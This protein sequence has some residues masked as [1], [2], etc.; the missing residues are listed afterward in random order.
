M[1]LQDETAKWYEQYYGRFGSDRNNILKDKGVLWQHLASE[2]SLI[3]S[4]ASTN[5]DYA[6]AK[7][8]DI[9]CGSGSLLSKLTHIGFNPQNLTGIDISPERIADGNMKYPNISLQCGDAQKLPFSTCSYDLTCESTMFVQITDERMS[10]EIAKEMIRVTKVGGFILLRDWRY[11]KFWDNS[12]LACCKKRVSQ[13][14]Q[15]GT[16]TVL[17]GTYRGAI[18]PPL[19]RF[20]SKNLPASYFLVSSLFPASVGEVVYLLRKVKNV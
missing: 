5:L 18:I 9:G 15:V 17:L 7:V 8:C 19:G 16:S 12:Y 1:D 14:F 3:R 11:G 13:M 6:N 4:V 10:I 2:Q 20:L